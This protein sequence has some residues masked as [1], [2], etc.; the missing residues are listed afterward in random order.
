MTMTW[1][2]LHNWR[3]TSQLWRMLPTV[4]EDRMKRH[5]HYV[6]CDKDG[7]RLSSYLSSGP[8]KNVW[9]HAIDKEF[10]QT[11]GVEDKFEFYET[12]ELSDSVQVYVHTSICGVLD[13]YAIRF[14]V[15]GLALPYNTDEEQSGNV[16]RIRPPGNM[17]YTPDNIRRFVLAWVNKNLLFG[18]G[19]MRDAQLTMGLTKK[20][21]VKWYRNEIR[22]KDG[23]GLPYHETDAIRAINRRFNVDISDVLFFEGVAWVNKHGRQDKLVVLCHFDDLWQMGLDGDIDDFEAAYWDEV[24]QYPNNAVFV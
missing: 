5:T 12:T 2:T 18:G 13:D 4:P 8:Y 19:L 24:A 6:L 9:W 22:R 21:V 23:D 11:F 10:K 16:F 15:H 1:N 20:G 17:E 3:Q 14:T 7:K